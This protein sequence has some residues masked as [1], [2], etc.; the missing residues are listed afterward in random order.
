MN[1]MKTNEKFLEAFISLESLCA[2][3]LGIT[4]AGVSEYISRLSGAKMAI[5]RDET[6]KQLTRFRKVRNRLVHENGALRSLGEI[7]QNDI[8][9]LKRFE[10][11]VKKS[12]DPL[13]RYYKQAKGDKR[14]KILL[15]CLAALLF[16]ASVAAIYL[17]INWM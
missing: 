7:S 4:T 12:K 8:K 1:H 15:A 11:S 14:K 5:G 2:D 10:K 16:A 6:V 17:A 9:W 3:K 13:S